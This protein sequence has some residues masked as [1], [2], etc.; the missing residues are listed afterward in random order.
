[1]AT[2]CSIKDNHRYTS[3][4]Y[5][6]IVSRYNEIYEI[7]KDQGIFDEVDYEKI[8]LKEFMISEYP[9]LMEIYLSK[10]FSTSDAHENVMRL[11]AMIPKIL[12]KGMS[13]K[14]DVLSDNGNDVVGSVKFSTAMSKIGISVADVSNHLDMLSAQETAEDYIQLIQKLVVPSTDNS[15]AEDVNSNLKNI[16]EEEPLTK[17]QKEN[18]PNRTIGEPINYSF[19]GQNTNYNTVPKDYNI[20]TIAPTPYSSASTNQEQ[21]LGSKQEF[22]FN[23][24]RNLIAAFNKAKI[25]NTEFQIDGKS[26]FITAMNI[27]ELPRSDYG[28][29]TGTYADLKDR[30]VNVYTDREGVPFR[31]NKDGLFDR[32]GEV[33]YDLLP[34]ANSVKGNS[35]NLNI[36]E[37]SGVKHLAMLEGISYLEAEKMYSDQL[38]LLDSLRRKV[39]DRKS[40]PNN[41]ELT[42]V[43]FELNGGTLGF[44]TGDSKNRNKVSDIN[45]DN[46]SK[47]IISKVEDKVRGFDLN[48]LYIVDID[49][50]HGQ[51][52]RIHTNSVDTS[53]I[54]DDVFLADYLTDL[55][56]LDFENVSRLELKN[57]IDQYLFLENEDKF[58]IFV[59]KDSEGKENYKIYFEGQ[60]IDH[61]SPNAREEIRSKFSEI[62]LYQEVTN[63]TDK[64]IIFAK[65]EY[66]QDDIDSIVM[67]K[68]KNGTKYY[69]LSKMKFKTASSGNSNVLKSFKIKRIKKENGVNSLEEDASL[70]YSNFIRNNTYT[71]ANLSL[72]RKLE[73]MGAYV[74]YEPTQS[75]LESVGATKVKQE[76][77]S[78]EE[79]VGKDSESKN[80][81]STEG[82]MYLSNQLTDEEGRRYS[83]G[84]INAKLLEELGYDEFDAELILAAKCN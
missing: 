32:S 10:D 79:V 2:V 39:L 58:K 30:V 5:D 47:I 36:Y 17:E 14:L 45:L 64:K 24:R 67:V 1:M 53:M 8:S 56:T 77:A 4:V 7:T 25:S 68:N 72:D 78:I 83:Y 41:N 60:L 3:R 40:N 82:S 74:T 63:I 51:P 52:A 73:K 22:Y 70:S 75:T 44:S 43:Q 15:Y 55:M 84:E 49:G 62:N 26:V 31:F 19:V 59:T 6:S 37:K 48:R 46:K 65:K 66:S 20:V 33:A 71:K 11:I 9:K 34:K 80:E 28:T 21:S 81:E 38:I 12:D 29:G 76:I 27:E 23:V 61:T 57:I 50:Y 16:T 35:V 69:N 42:S 18:E 13:Q 54:Y